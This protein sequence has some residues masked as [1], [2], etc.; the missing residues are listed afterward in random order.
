MLCWADS[1]FRRCAAPA[2]QY[3]LILYYR[4]HQDLEAVKFQ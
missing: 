4:E 2:D 3:W 1:D